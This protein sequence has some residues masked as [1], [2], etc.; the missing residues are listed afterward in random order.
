MGKLVIVLANGEIE[1]PVQLRQRLAAL[2][3]A[4][5]IAADGGSQHA[6][7]LGLRVAILVGDQDSLDDSLRDQFAV[8]DVRF[9]SHSS[10]KDETDLELALLQAKK[11]GA[12][13]IIVIGAMG[14]RMDMTLANLLLLAH[15]DLMDQAIEIWQGTQTARIVRPPGR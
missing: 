15:P 6:D 1:N 8:N 14:G 10:Q 13:K 4:T 7:L 5:V 12:Q 11:E 3:A 2:D 9:E